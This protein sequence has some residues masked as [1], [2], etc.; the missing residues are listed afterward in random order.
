MS[1]RLRT[2][3]RWRRF[4]R[5]AVFLLTLSTLPKDSSPMPVEQ[6][7]QGTGASARVQQ[8]IWLINQ[9]RQDPTF[10]GF[11]SPLWSAMLEDADVQLALDFF[12]VDMAALQFQLSSAVAVA[13][14]VHD[15]GIADVALAHSVLMQTHDVQSHQ[16]PGEDGLLTRMAGLLPAG[17]VSIGENVFAY[18][19]SSL[20]GF[21]SFA[22]DWG[23]GPGG[24]QS[25]AGHRA[26]LLD[27]SFD[28]VG[29]G[30]SE[31]SDADTLVGPLLITQDF[32]SGLASGT[33]AAKIVGTVWEDSN[34]NGI[35]DPGEGISGASVVPDQGLYFAVTD[36]SGGYVLPFVE[37]DGS[38][39]QTDIDVTIAVSVRGVGHAT[40][41]A[42]ISPFTN[43]LVDV[44]QFNAVP[45][46]SVSMLAAA[47]LLLALG[48]RSRAR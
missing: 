17:G 5:A 33:A 8:Q 12:G 20:Y 21:A 16:L 29:I 2:A 27:A 4:L 3:I 1:S 10:S 13:P 19:L 47:L 26:N 40:R 31:D 39:F 35:F 36:A 6:W 28:Y 30:I 23:F 44:A 14:L 9:F 37:E 22:I 45:E 34:G 15:Q 24:I 48:S 11:G 32:M 46:P 42:T 25:A 38:S 41:P 43:L 7:D 18:A